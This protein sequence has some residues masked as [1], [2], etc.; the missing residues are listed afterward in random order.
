MVSIVDSKLKEI[1]SRLVAEF[2]P[3]KVYL[4]GS[5]ARGDS[6]EDSDYD[7]LL[8]VPKEIAYSHSSYE[9][10]A[11][12]LWGLEFPT[13]ILL[14]SR[15]DFDK[16]LHLKASLPATVVREGQLLHAS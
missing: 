9:K 6:S 11:E 13:D 3:E 1:V 5:Q 2:Q 14:W 12:L 7:L 10:V 16:R 15:E 4:F 8:I